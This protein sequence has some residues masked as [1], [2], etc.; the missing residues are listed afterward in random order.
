M[1]EWFDPAV[2]QVTID[3]EEVNGLHDLQKFEERDKYG[4]FLRGNNGL[5]VIKSSAGPGDGSRILVIKDSYGNSFVPY[6]LYNYDE[7]QV[8]DLRAMAG[9]MSDLLAENDYDDILL[10]YSFMNFAS[11]QNIPKLRY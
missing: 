6:L 4:A 5:T 9:K 1:I 2:E 3:G 10:L 8:V 7:V 11:D